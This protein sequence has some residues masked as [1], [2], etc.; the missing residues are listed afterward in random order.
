MIPIS[1]SEKFCCQNLITSIKVI[2]M[3]RNS[4]KSN[5]LRNINT[6]GCRT[7]PAADRTLSTYLPSYLLFLTVNEVTLPTFLNN[8]SP[9]KLLKRDF[10]VILTAY[11][12]CVF[13]IFSAYKSSVFYHPAVKGE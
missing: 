12:L 9:I 1:L 13:F 4:S 8:L 7:S 6:I 10:Y 11:Y 5:K 2:N 3:T